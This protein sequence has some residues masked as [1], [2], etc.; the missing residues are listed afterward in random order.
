M[1]CGRFPRWAS[2]SAAAGR[3]SDAEKV[4]LICD[5][6]NTHTKG[7]FYEVFKPERARSLVKKIEFRYTPKHG[8]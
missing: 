4:I 2:R 5:N 1:N 6:L 8:S 7:A 3:Y